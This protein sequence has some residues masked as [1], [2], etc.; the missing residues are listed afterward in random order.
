MKSKNELIR[1]IRT[2]DDRVMIDAG[3]KQN[4]RGAYLCPDAACFKKARKS[5]S[6]ARALKISIP[7]EVYDHLMKEMKEFDTE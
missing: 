3:G 1:V 6:F 7:E 4:G 2:P 5:G